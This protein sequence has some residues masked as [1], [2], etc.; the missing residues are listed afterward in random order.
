MITGDNWK[1]LW[2]RQ[3]GN[4]GK[5]VAQGYIKGKKRFLRRVTRKS[6]INYEEVLN[7]KISDLCL[8]LHLAVWYNLGQGSET[9]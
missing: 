2:R 5:N 4:I 9:L 8:I 3:G 6:S 7:L 1:S